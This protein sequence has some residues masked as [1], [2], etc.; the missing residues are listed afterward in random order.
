MI[1]GPV[2]RNEHWQFRD[3][4][5]DLDLTT[6]IEPQSY[7]GAEIRLPTKTIPLSFDQ[8]KQSSL[9]AFRFTDGATWKEI[10]SGKGKIFWSSYSAELAEGL[11]PAAS[12]YNYI[13]AVL[14]IRPAFESQSSIPSGVL[15]STTELQDSVLYI[16]ESENTN[17]AA[18]DLRDVLTGVRLTLKL[19]AQRAALALIGKREKAV[20]A[21]YGF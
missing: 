20:I 11:E 9:D 12:V 17:N 13:L 7:R 21:R 3:R 16:L 4:P 14:K 19:P 6:K 15:I 2:S 18:I 10:S 1:T 8:Q 5:R